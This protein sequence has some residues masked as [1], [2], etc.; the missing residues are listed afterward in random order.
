VEAPSKLPR[1]LRAL[2]QEA[3]VTEAGLH[4]TVRVSQRRNRIPGSSS[5]A[6][7]PACHSVLTGPQRTTTD[8]AEAALT[9]APS[10]LRR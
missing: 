4:R 5:T 6:V 3:V 10:H 9:C 7:P 1:A 8:N 2:A